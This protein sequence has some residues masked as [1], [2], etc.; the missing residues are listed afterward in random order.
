MAEALEPLP[1]PTHPQR[2]PALGVE[3]LRP[4]PPQP[5]LAPADDP[6]AP[7][8]R[9]LDFILPTI[10]VEDLAAGIDVQEID[11]HDSVRSVSGTT[12]PRSRP[13]AAPPDPSYAVPAR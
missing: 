9:L 1:D 3:D 6:S 13:P 8:L 11:R 4:E 2:H 7:G 10:G 5:S 12:V